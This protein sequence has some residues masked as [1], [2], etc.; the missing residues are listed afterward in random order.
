MGEIP[1]IENLPENVTIH[2]CH[3]FTIPLLFDDCLSLLQKVCAL[4]AKTNEIISSLSEWNADFSDWAS[5]VEGQL[6]DLKEKYTQ[7][8][9][10]VTDNSSAISELERDFS[11]IETD[12]TTIK[13]RLNQLQTSVNNLSGQ[14]TNLTDMLTE[15]RDITIPEIQSDLTTLTDRVSSLEN[16]LKN[17]NIV[18]PI[19]IFNGDS[20]TTWKAVYDAWWNWFSN[21]V[22]DFTTRLPKSGWEMSR[23][24]TWY[25]TVTTP[26]RLIQVGYL[27]QPVCRA[28]LPFIAVYKKAYTSLPTFQNIIEQFPHFKQTNLIPSNAFFN[29]T[30]NNAYPAVI[31]EIKVTTSY[32]PFLPSGSSLFK[33]ELSNNSEN[34]KVFYTKTI[35]TDFRLVVTKNQTTGK[36][37]CIPTTMTFGV[38]PSE[39]FSSSGAYDVYIY[40][41]AENG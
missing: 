15:I 39:D 30:L 26:G 35:N 29:F 7:L 20:D 2:W 23:N 32:I 11:A 34:S 9:T 21:Y 19:E 6:S 3:Q 4:W 14:V 41:I 38:V 24:L 25:D 12:L 36:L 27:G 31:D 5:G 17:L 28:K 18:P 40:C 8:E 33:M 16:L 1:N 37:C 13:N 10:K 22:I